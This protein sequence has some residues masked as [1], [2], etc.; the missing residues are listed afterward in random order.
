MLEAT[1]TSGFVE[2]LQAAWDRGDAVL[3]VDPRLPAPARDALL[4]SL[5]PD[6][7]VEE[8]D[9]LVLA[10]SGSTGK[11]RG[12]VLTHDA[13]RAS[14]L[15]VSRRIGVVAHGG[16]AGSCD[17][18]WLAC[19]P[20]AH[21]G[22]LSVVTR[23]LLT[24]VPLEIHR[25]FDAAAVD[26]SPASLVSL[27]PT[28]LRR[29]R[30]ERFRVILLGGSAPPAGLPPNVVSTYGMTETAGGVVHD[31]VPLEGV[32]ARV[33]AI[34]QLRVRGPMLLRCYR[35]GSDP[36]DPAGWFA[37]GD[38]AAITEGRVTVHGRLDDLIVTGGENVWPTLVE[39][40]L[41][42]HPAVAD[43]A[44][45]GLADPEWGQRVVALVVP[46]DGGSPPTLA[47]LRAWVTDHLPAYAAP[48]QVVLVETVPRTASGKVRRHA[49][50]QAAAGLV[51]DPV[52]DRWTTGDPGRRAAP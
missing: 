33:D 45:T 26:A 27:V 51:D 41:V 52:D 39:E 22:G 1:G 25:S 29:I 16:D 18:C 42:R 19:L 23:A 46:S 5:R 24:G 4:A 14:A 11:P 47:A 3:P 37:T 2:A 21:V 31:G 49:L 36:K 44:V 38:S 8:G 35:D 17:D 13:L 10:T 6:E 9:A 40:A 30:P 7:P 28:A 15:A 48:K 34:G 43:A 12:V 20:L 50:G 32:E